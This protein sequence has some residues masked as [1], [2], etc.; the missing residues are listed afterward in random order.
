V[1]VSGTFIKDQLEGPVNYY[2]KNGAKEITGKFAYGLRQGTWMY[3][4]KDGS[5]RYQAV[6]RQGDIVKEKRE[7]GTFEERGPDDIL[8]SSYIYKNGL[9]EGPFSEYHDDFSYEYEEVAD[10]LTGETYFRQVL[11]GNE[12]KKEGFYKADMLHGEVKIYN[13]KGILIEKQNYINGELQ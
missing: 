13:E 8:L 11:I 6:Y 12:L 2:F 4:N 1:K 7:N 5:I 10:K 3:F 9:R